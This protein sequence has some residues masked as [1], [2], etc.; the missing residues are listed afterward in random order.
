MK[1]IRLTTIGKVI[2]FFLVVIVCLALFS[3]VSLLKRG[4]ETKKIDKP[5]EVDSEKIIDYTSSKNYSFDFDKNDGFKSEN[6]VISITESGTYKLNGNNDKYKFVVD[7]PNGVVKLV[8]SN[9]KTSVV[10]DLISVKS[11]N[12]LIIELE[13][14]SKNSIISDLLENADSELPTIIKSNSDIEFVGGGKLVVETIGNFLISKA[15]LNFKDAILEI[16]NI[17]NG[18]KIDGNF[19]MESGTL[20]ILSSAKGLVTSGNTTISDGTFILR[21]SESAIKV[22]GIFLLNDGKIFIASLNEIQKPNANS[23]QKTIILNFKEARTKLLFFH[24]TTQVTLAYA[25]DLSYQHILYSDE[26]K[27]ENYVLYGSGKIAGTQTYGLYKLEDTAEDGQL[28]CEGLVNDRFSVKNLVNVY[29]D[30]VKK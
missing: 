12:K 26:F 23:L 6:N 22:S 15:N 10:Y 30:I 2:W 5:T 7:C 16:N 1:P 28:T 9:F 19:T 17:N 18:I 29:D 14:G 20:Y 24:D 8:V 4:N 27:T 13:D 21:S 25:G 11:A 3:L